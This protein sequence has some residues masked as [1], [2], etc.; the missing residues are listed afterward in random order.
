M[1]YDIKI[2]RYTEEKYV[3]PHLVFSLLLVDK[4]GAHRYSIARI[5]SANC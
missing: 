3:I 4:S 5:H 1:S 2:I